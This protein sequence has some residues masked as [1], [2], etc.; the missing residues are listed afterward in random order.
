MEKMFLILTHIQR[1]LI[2][3]RLIEN[4]YLELKLTVNL[5]SDSVV[6]LL[7]IRESIVQ[8]LNSKNVANC[9]IK[10]NLLSQMV[11]KNN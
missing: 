4:Q 2:I 6:K 8:T 7:T 11:V 1:E 3:E 5:S 9:K 10:V